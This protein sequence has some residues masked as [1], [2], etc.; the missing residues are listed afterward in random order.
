MASLRRLSLSA[1]RNI[2]QADLRLQAGTNVFYGANGSGKTSLLEAVHL[3]ASGR[4]F[5]SRLLQSVVQEGKAGLTV[6]GELESGLTLGVQKQLGGGSRIHINQVPATSSSQLA[7]SLPLQVI[8]S[9]SF[10][11]LNGGP[12]VRRRLLDWTVFHVEHRFMEVWK[13][14]QVA[15]RQRNAL[16]RQGRVDVGLLSLWEQRLAESGTEVDQLRTGVYSRLSAETAGLL[17][18][19]EESPLRRIV[20]SYRR[21]WKKDRPLAEAL[22]DSRDADMAQGFGRSGPHRADLHFSVGGE[23]AH[24]ILSRGQQKMLVCVLRAAMAAVV[25]REGEKPLFLIDDL[26]AELDQDNQ[27]QFAQW[28]S[29]CAAQVVVTGI[30]GDITSRPWRRLESP[31]NQ[32]A[33]FHVEHGHINSRPEMGSQVERSD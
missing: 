5:R 16:L 25:R 8:H 19:L 11:A 3:L 10:A 14:Y 23:A 26:P 29:R 15:L 21:G 32:P 17:E 18:Q 24:N 6:F 30:D 27:L 33:M 7:T 1:F 20:M 28:I 9:E 13:R 22:R 12:G 31:W 2:E 4:S